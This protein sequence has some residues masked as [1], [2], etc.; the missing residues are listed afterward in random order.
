MECVIII[1]AI[2]FINNIAV[3]GNIAEQP[4][5]GVYCLYMF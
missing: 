5:F 1:P 2:M 3:H 4:K